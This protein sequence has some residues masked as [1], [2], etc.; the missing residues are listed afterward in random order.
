LLENRSGNLLNFVKFFNKN[1]NLTRR[2]ISLQLIYILSRIE[3]KMEYLEEIGMQ[4]DILNKL[5]NLRNLILFLTNEKLKRN[6]KTNL[7]LAQEST[8]FEFRRKT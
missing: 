4:K 7:L 5:L 8:L 2:E 6:R 1:L 3:E